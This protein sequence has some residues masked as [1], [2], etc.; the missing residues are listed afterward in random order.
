MRTA[1]P[2]LPGSSHM[3]ESPVDRALSLL[4]AEE[5]EAALRWAAAIVKQDP[6][7]ATALLVSGGLHA[8]HDHPPL[9]IQSAAH[10][11]PKPTARAWGLRDGAAPPDRTPR[12][13]DRSPRAVL[14]EREKTQLGCGG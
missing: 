2:E 10:A 1:A 12:Q 7:M 6:L 13:L 5:R 4:F 8:R 9:G 14:E 11:G 3:L